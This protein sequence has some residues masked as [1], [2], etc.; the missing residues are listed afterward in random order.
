[1]RRLTVV[2]IQPALRYFPCF[3]Q[4]SE[5]IQTQDFCPV[6]PV[7]SFD[8]RVLRRLTQYVGRS[9]KVN[10]PFWWDTYSYEVGKGC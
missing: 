6:G 9:L 10:G 5:Q 1:M 8:K 3:I 4:Y 2:L 7:K